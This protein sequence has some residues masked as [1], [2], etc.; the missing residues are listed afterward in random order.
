M[1]RE[2]EKQ[3]VKLEEDNAFLQKE[4]VKIGHMLEQGKATE[5]EIN[6]MKAN[7]SRWAA[8]PPLRKAE[9]TQAQAEER[10]PKAPGPCH[11]KAEGRE[12]QATQAWGS[13]RQPKKF[14]QGEVSKA[15][16]AWPIGQ[17]GPKP[18]PPKTPPPDHLLH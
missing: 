9:G 4:H 3:I 6:N 1:T 14:K 12:A 18:Q 13:L 8:P 15:T 2:K 11:P 16:Q 17:V 5:E 10:Q 7:R